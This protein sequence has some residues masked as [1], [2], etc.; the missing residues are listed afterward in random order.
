MDAAY[1]GGVGGRILL[2]LLLQGRRR[3]KS[4]GQREDGQ[5]SDALFVLQ[6]TVGT[7][8]TILLFLTLQSHV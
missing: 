1:G 5:E 3:R 6:Y 2:P 4:D 7:I 8:P